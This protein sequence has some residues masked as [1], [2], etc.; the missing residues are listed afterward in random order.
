MASGE[1]RFV[2]SDQAHQKE[3][4]ARLEAVIVAVLFSILISFFPCRKGG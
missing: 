2:R 3:S 1:S 4:E